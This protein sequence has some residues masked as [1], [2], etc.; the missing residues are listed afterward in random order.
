MSEVVQVNERERRE[1][2]E[3]GID[4]EPLPEVLERLCNA[5][6]GIDP[7][8]KLDEWL[9]SKAEEEIPLLK[10]DLEREQLRLEQRLFRVDSISKRIEPEV[11]T[12]DSGQRNLFDCFDIIERIVP[13]T[14]QKHSSEEEEEGEPH[15][16]K[17]LLDYLPGEMSDD[18]LLAVVAQMVLLEID[19]LIDNNAEMVPMEIL[20]EL[21]NG[22]GISNEEVDEAIDHLLLTGAIHEVDEDCFVPDE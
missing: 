18:P 16:A 12:V 17:S 2:E 6:Q 9:I 5:M 1:A 15:P 7:D 10:M 21:L 11:D 4:A 14:K 3:T 19:S 22:R 8:W 13:E 20:C